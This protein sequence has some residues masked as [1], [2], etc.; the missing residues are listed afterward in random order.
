M[1]HLCHV[2]VLLVNI[3]SNFVFFAQISVNIIRWLISSFCGVQCHSNVTPSLYQSNCRHRLVLTPP[4]PPLPLLET[5]TLLARHVETSRD[6]CHEGVT[7]GGN[8]AAWRG[9]A[10]LW[11]HYCLQSSYCPL[12][13][14]PSLPAPGLSSGQRSTWQDTAAT[15]PTVSN[16]ESPWQNNKTKPFR[17]Q[18]L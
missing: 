11:G 5:Q 13:N 9:R 12:P 1:C 15:R 16:V 7:R 18:E 3:F 17:E 10:P 2:T 4:L 8:G 6:K 14:Y